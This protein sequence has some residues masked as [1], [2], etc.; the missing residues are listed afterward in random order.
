[1]EHQ[2]VV[3]SFPTIC[4][5]VVNPYNSTFISLPHWANNNFIITD[6]KTG[7][8]TVLPKE[9]STGFASP[10]Y[11]KFVDEHTLFYHR[12]VNNHYQPHKGTYASESIFVDLRTGGEI[13]SVKHLIPNCFNFTV[14]G[15]S[16]TRQTNSLPKLECTGIQRPI[17]SPF[18]KLATSFVVAFA[19]AQI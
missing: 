5:S 4:D 7:Q 15:S 12:A 3:V 18:Y 14:S 6:W 19:D 1:M 16:Q 13:S 17:I 9:W 10:T 11:A 8:K 2:D